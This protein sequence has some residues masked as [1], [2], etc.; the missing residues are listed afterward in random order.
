MVTGAG[1]SIGSELARQVARFG[2]GRL[3][4]VERAEFALFEIDREL[5]GLHPELEIVPLVADVCDR[6]LMGPSSPACARQVVLHAA[7]HKHVPMME[8]N[9]V[10]AVKN[11][12]LATLAGGGGGGAG[13]EAFIQISTDKAVR[14]TSVMGASKR[15]A[16]LAVQDL[17]GARTGRA[18]CRC[19]SATCS[20]RRAR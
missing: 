10:E 16:E 14:P 9:P 6:G 7:A 5:R 3:L 17:N 11:N 15:V 12:V 19:A 1:G 13:V 20:A 2:A 8:S 18:S 4:L